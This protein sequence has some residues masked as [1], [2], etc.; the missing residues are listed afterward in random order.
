MEQLRYFWLYSLLLFQSP[1]FTQINL[2]PDNIVAGHAFGV[3]RIIKASETSSHSNIKYLPTNSQGLYFE[4]MNKTKLFSFGVKVSRSS[5]QLKY[6][7]GGITKEQYGGL[8]GLPASTK[9]GYSGQYADYSSRIGLAWLMYIGLFQSKKD[10]RLKLYT[11]INFGLEHVY[12]R[13]IQSN[14]YQTYKKSQGYSSHPPDYIIQPYSIYQI[15]EQRSFTDHYQKTTPKNELC[16][17]LILHPRFQINKK[18][19]AAL[20]I[21]RKFYFRSVL[22]DIPGEF[23]TKHNYCWLSL[24]WRIQRNIENNP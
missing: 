2:I 8:Q 15:K 7:T 17:E 4:W 14:N 5:V 12:E 23:L 24:I 6:S 20:E 22:G 11:G 3:T 21:T 9:E 1:V 19:H 13:T 18:F 10:P 16:F